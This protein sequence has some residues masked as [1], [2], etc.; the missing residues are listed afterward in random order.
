MTAIIVCVLA[1]CL[2]FSSA[3]SAQSASTSYNLD[4]E[5]NVSD[6]GY[7]SSASYNLVGAITNISAEGE[8]SSYNLRNVYAGLDAPVCG[9]YVIEA[10]EQ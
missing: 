4:Y 5:R 9:N 3:A 10:G 8:S 6:A 1:A 2:F 7:K